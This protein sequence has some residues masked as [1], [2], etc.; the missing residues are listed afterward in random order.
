MEKQKGDS[1][2]QVITPQQ[3][4]EKEWLDKVQIDAGRLLRYRLR[5]QYQE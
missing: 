5:R 2:G 3:Q 1:M 4:K